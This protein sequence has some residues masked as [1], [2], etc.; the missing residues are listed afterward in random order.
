MVTRLIAAFAVCMASSGCIYV[1]PPL[2]RE[3]P[4]APERFLTQPATE[5]LAIGEP[6]WGLAVSG[7]GI[8]SA[9]V[10]LGA[11]KALYDQDVLDRFD[12][13]STVSGGGYTGYWLYSREYDAPSRPNA[14]FG[15]GSFED[16]V[17]VE[18]VC[19]IATTNNFVNKFGVVAR[20]VTGQNPAESYRRSIR[21]TFGQATYDLPESYGT[22]YIEADTIEFHELRDLVQRRVVPN[23]IV[24]AR[25]YRP[26][27]QLGWAD[28]MY[29]LTPFHRGTASRGYFEWL[30]STSY[31]VLDGVAASG[32]AVAFALER[33]LP[34]QV[35]ANDRPIRLSD[36]G[37]GENLGAIALVRRRV[38]NI[39]IIDAEQDPTLSLKSYVNLKTRLL[40]WGDTLEIPK[41]D[42]IV[43]RRETSLRPARGAYVG[44]IHSPGY[45]AKVYYMKLSIPMSMNTPLA[46]DT[47]RDRRAAIDRQRIFDALEDG[48]RL[49]P[50][51]AWDCRHLRS[52][53]VDLRALGAY[54]VRM[55]LSAEDLASERVP[56]NWSKFPHISTFSLNYNL[57]RSMAQVAIGY[58]LGEE[59]AQDIRSGAASE[60][61]Q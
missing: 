2:A 38:P 25:V 22:G 32:A 49:S 24:N 23:L 46:P 59:L 43:E 45:H 1:K 28:G 55:F 40:A 3:R 26:I 20:W 52:L 30:G 37:H 48:T 12:V 61:R 44:T 41:L 33:T 15:A 16:S 60:A 31:D 5:R 18:A 35:A 8:R 14:G 42:T 47:E 58:M 10:A 6:K 56:E 54:E 11:L 39:V 34:T 29:E 4:I 27:P 57:D 21:R 50:S 36:G 9:T 17:F 7:G 53:Q 51:Q 13:I 19:G